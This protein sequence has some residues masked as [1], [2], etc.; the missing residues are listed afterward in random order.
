MKAMIVAHTHWDREWYEPFAVFQQRLVKL[1]D[2]LLELLPREPAFRHF[3]LDGQS[4]MID[5]YLALRPEREP[6]LRE[7]FRTGRL[8][9]G[10]WFTQMDEFL[11]SGESMIRNLEWGLARARSLG[12][13]QPVGGPWAGYL[14]DQFGHIG[15]MPQLL[16]RAGIDR[17]VLWRGVPSAIDRATFTWRSP[18]GSDVL[19]EYYAYGYGLGERISEHL[20]SARSLA[21]EIQR[22]VGLA[23]PL[24]DRETV[25]IPVGGDHSV[26]LG[27]FNPGQKLNA[28][29]VGAP[30]RRCRQSNSLS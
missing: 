14:P 6:E 17:A 26:R 10:P 22:V 18:D 15:Q 4:A 20:D 3:H 28:V 29:F 2:G 1:F 19:A 16:R 9:I 30:S 11:T 13:E 12:I 21:G 8:S 23:A 27:K 5:D 24:A 25:I 7:L